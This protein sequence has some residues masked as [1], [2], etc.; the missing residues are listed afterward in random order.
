MQIDIN[1]MSITMVSMEYVVM[2]YYPTARGHITSK[3]M[4][5]FSTYNTDI[6]GVFVNME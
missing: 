2:G 3:A 6:T 5:W 4:G 1:C